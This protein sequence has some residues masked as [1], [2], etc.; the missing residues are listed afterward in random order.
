[1]TS[2]IKG[3]GGHTSLEPVLS[4]KPLSDDTARTLACLVEGDNDVFAVQVMGNE[5]VYNL[6]NSIQQARKRTLFRDVD[7]SDILLFKVNS[8][9]VC[10]RQSCSYPLSGSE[11]YQPT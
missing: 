7:T 6:V 5:G 1:M 8:V 3:L 10:R 11:S 2:P 9:L 4:Q